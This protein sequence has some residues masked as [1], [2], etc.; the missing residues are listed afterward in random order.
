MWLLT[1]LCKQDGLPLYINIHFEEEMGGLH[2]IETKR[3]L[4]E[5]SMKTHCCVLY[6][7]KERRKKRY[8]LVLPGQ[9][10]LYFF[11]EEELQTES[12]EARVRSSGRDQFLKH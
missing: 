8:C 1:L 3:A 2:G 10:Q 9:R 4:G 7:D 11:R 12:R 5:F 6:K